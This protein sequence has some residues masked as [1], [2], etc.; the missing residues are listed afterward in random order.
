MK[1]REPRRTVFLPARLRETAGWCD[2]VVRNVSSRGMLLESDEP[3]ARGSYIEVRRASMTIVGRVVWRRDR[4]VG[5]R[6]QDR[7]DIDLLVSGR[8]ATAAC[9]G[10]H[11]DE[12]HAPARVAART[13]ENS[14]ALGG[15]MER[16][17]LIAIALAAAAVA[18]DR[19]Y[20]TLA[21]PFAT[22]QQQLQSTGDR[23]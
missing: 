8:P 16:S 17:A 14:R 19:V 20:A 18:A 15:W 5:V 6:A 4:L 3:P 10:E 9:P 23:D 21:T 1:P 22:V 13:W 12:I 2:A 11:I 7:I